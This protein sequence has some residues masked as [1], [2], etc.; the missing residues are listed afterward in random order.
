MRASGTDRP[1]ELVRKDEDL[2]VFPERVM[3]AGEI[4]QVLRSGGRPER[5][6]LISQLLRY[7]E[8]E[9]IWTYISRDEV[10]Q[11]WADL[12]LSPSLRQAWARILGISAP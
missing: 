3:T 1:S 6:W 8:W 9:E 12:D 5:A 4:R 11:L 10:R 7:A 2:Y